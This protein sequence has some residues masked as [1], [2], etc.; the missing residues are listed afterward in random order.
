MIKKNSNCSKLCIIVNEYVKSA[1]SVFALSADELYFI[2]I[3]LSVREMLCGGFQA[4]GYIASAFIPQLKDNVEKEN[5][6]E[7]VPE[8]NCK[9]R[10]G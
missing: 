6:L 4:L 7:Y 8:S 10:Q 5:L 9:S 2:P 1:A 3:I